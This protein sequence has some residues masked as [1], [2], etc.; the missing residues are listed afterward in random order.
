MRSLFF[1][2]IFACL[3]PGIGFAAEPITAPDFT[4]E[5]VGGDPVTLSD[6]TAEQPV[7][8]LF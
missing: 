4:L 1:L 7:I 5:S 2:L 3:L 8:L 6:V